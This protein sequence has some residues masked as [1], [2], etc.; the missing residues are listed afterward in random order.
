V[1]DAIGS[2]QIRDLHGHNTVRNH[3]IIQISNGDW[4]WRRP[5][6]FVYGPPVYIVWNP[7]A[8]APTTNSNSRSPSALATSSPASAEIKADEC[9]SV[10][11]PPLDDDGVSVK[12]V[13][14]PTGWRRCPCDRAHR[15]SRRLAAAVVSQQRREPL[16]PARSTAHRS[17]GELRT[18]TMTVAATVIL[19]S[20]FL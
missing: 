12:W 20:F 18:R 17:K 9:R 15:V 10:Q 4:M 5:A 14:R 6:D 11:R 3:P 1:G 19:V 7:V 16:G 8:Q 13:C 2:Q